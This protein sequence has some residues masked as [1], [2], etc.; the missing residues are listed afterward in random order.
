MLARALLVLA[1]ALLFAA[2]ATNGAPPLSDQERCLRYGGIWQ[3][4]TCK[5]TG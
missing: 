5:A 2:C 4:G 1:A 3:S